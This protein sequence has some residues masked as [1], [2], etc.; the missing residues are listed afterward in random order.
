M[1]MHQSKHKEK[2][3]GIVETRVGSS[4]DAT[5]EGILTKISAS[6]DNSVSSDFFLLASSFGRVKCL[7]RLDEFE[8]LGNIEKLFEN[9]QKILINKIKRNAT[10]LPIIVVLV[11]CLPTR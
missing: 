10:K 9:N 7:G 3:V 2:H 11:F 8:C 5:G 4:S 1:V 6:F